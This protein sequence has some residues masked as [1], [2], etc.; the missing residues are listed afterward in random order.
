LINNSQKYSVA[1]ALDI[2]S[3]DVYKRGKEYYESGKVRKILTSPIKC[4]E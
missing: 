2:S 1:L 3:V 4:P